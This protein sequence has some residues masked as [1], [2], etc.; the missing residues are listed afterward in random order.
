MDNKS[1][2]G[3][4]VLVVEDEMMVLMHIENMLLDAGA[5]VSPAAT[6]KQAQ[7]LID[8]QDF[9][10]AM[11]DVNLNGTKS[12]PVAETLAERGVPFI[13]A[14]GYGAHG[15]EHPFRDRPVLKK[16]FQSDELVMAL[17]RLVS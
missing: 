7:A 15:M 2:S 3:R 5:S 14:T 17:I 4:R 10:V 9:D 12:F 6:V 11:L 13:F 16:P 1:L 8:T